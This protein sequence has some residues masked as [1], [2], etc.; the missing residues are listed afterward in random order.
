[1]KTEKPIGFRVE[2]IVE[3]DEKSFHAYC[4][5][6]KG[7]HTCGKTEAE[8]LKNAKYAAKAYL[9]SLVKHGDSIPLGI[10]LRKE[11]RSDDDCSKPVITYH[12]ED[13]KVT[14]PI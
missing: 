5:A 3:P 1:M 13:L 6:L 2:I 11:Q 8:A 12:V 7:L 10:E 14:C 9:A 4:P